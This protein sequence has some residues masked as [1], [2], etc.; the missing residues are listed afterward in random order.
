MKHCSSIIVF[1]FSLFSA[2]AQ[3]IQ[4]EIIRS[5][6]PNHTISGFN[7]YHKDNIVMAIIEEYPAPDDPG[8]SKVRYAMTLHTSNNGGIDWYK[9]T[10]SHIARIFNDFARVKAFSYCDS[11]TIIGVG[12]SGLIVRTI[13]GG[14][15]WEKIQQKKVLEFST[16][17]L[18]RKLWHC[19]RYLW[20][21]RYYYRCW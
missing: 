10:V 7:S 9:D 4:W 3:S 19:G 12:D 16:Y 11:L 21:C 13:D 5:N 8:F 6:N 2:S 17:R 1:L 15:H 18:Q 14:K 20:H